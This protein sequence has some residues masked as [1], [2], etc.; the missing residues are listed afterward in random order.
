MLFA[1]AAAMCSSLSAA[2]MPKNN[3][4]LELYYDGAWHDLVANDDVFAD[5][6]ITITRGQGDEGVAPRPCTIGCRLANDDD[7]YRT[8][9]PESPLWGKAG[10]NTPMR[11]SV[12]G[13]VR[14]QAEAS[15]W[16]AGQTRDFRARP[17]RGKAWVDVQAG[18]L[19]QRINQWTEPLKSAF[20][21]YNEGLSHVTGYWPGE[22]V[23]GSTELISVTPG[24]QQ[25]FFQ[26]IA[27]ESQYRPLGSA[28]L[29]DMGSSDDAEVG[30]RFAP[31]TSA[32]PTA[33]W[34]LSWAG[35]YEPLVDG[36][37]DIMD[38]AT[39][40]GTQYGL[41]LN[42]TTGQILIYSTKSGVQIL[43]SGGSY[44]SYDWS[45]WTL[46]SI[47]AQYS[48]G[49][50]TV[51]IN[52]TNA[53]NTQSGF[54]A[55]SFSGAP[56]QLVWWDMSV[57]AGVPGGSTFGHVLG[58]N[59]SS[60]GGVNLFSVARIF[61]WTGYLRETAGARFVRL[62]NLKNIAY[63]VSSGYTGSTPMGPQPVATFAEQLREISATDDALI[64]D[65]RTALRLYML[66]GVDRYNLNSVLTLNAADNPT[67]MPALPTEVTDDLGVHNIIT[68][69]QRDGGEYVLRDDTSVMG[70]QPPPNGRGEYEQ[71][72][73]VNVADETTDLPQV[74]SW[75]LN[76]GTLTQA[77][78]P[79]VTVNLAALDPAGVAEVEQAD[80]GSIITIINFRE[81]T[82]R[83]WVLGYTETIG[84]P[85]TRTIT[86]TCAPDEIYG[87]IAVLD[88]FRLDS[89]TTILK[90]A[91]TQSD[92]AVTFRTTNIL[93][94]WDT[95]S[96]PFDVKIA[97]QRNRVT[98]VGAASLV[99]G[100]YDQAVTLVRGVDGIRKQLAAGEPVR[101]AAGY[102]RLAL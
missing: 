69:S 100:A 57:F 98:S 21:Q 101:L 77:R 52:W 24:T 46:F 28:P 92:T 42:P 11:V 45:Q 31:N 38:W 34:Q 83:L 67:G 71:R 48:A 62:C 16:Q 68:A 22:Q 15:S 40:D 41:Y 85:N 87:T 90:A 79:Q 75:W 84:W 54:F 89:A 55:P 13:V 18:G 73:D 81:Y 66:C 64:L 7:M 86:F 35:R 97:G 20:R 74:A 47:D 8:S 65:H 36:E 10:V 29:M 82:V 95:G 4:A 27:P 80:V 49:T 61:A 19:L 25:I 14:G 78:F 43:A 30:G 3:V 72:V 17:K 56:E 70:T 6:P 33:G 63:V 12:G 50:T 32:D 1:V 51:W 26:S 5:T 102:G 60:L 53:D 58:A 94:V 96:A 91:V 59:V 88:Q 99:S 2:A 44:G 37:Q 93:D 76:K 9:N 39:T 23:R